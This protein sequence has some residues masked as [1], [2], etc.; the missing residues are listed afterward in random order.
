D[1]GGRSMSLTDLRNAFVASSPADAEVKTFFEEWLDRAGAPN[2]GL[3][4]QPGG[5]DAAPSV[6]VTLSQ[7]GDVYHMPIKIVVVAGS[8]SSTHVVR[9]TR[10]EETFTFPSSGR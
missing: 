6:V 2:V 3:R 8:D 7:Q 4:W 9:L 1:F 10:A 5:S